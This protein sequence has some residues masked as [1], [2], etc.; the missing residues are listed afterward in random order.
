KD[1]DGKW[2]WS[3][4]KYSFGDTI[5]YHFNNLSPSKAGREYTL[6]LPLYNSVKWMDISVPSASSFV[7]NV[8]RKEKPIIVYGT[9]IAQGVS[10]TRPGLAWTN[11]LDRRLDIPLINLAFSGNGKLEPGVLDLIAEK[12]AKLY[13]LDCLPNLT[14]VATPEFKKL[15]ND[16]ISF[17]RN[18]RP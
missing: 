12:D 7:P 4:G 5:T 8:P 3:A 15:V 10:A 13:V 17:L 11:I 2:I 6:Y 14:G 18:K 16:A 9:S 1:Q